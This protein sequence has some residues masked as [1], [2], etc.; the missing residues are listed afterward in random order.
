M[1]NQAEHPSNESGTEENTLFKETL[2]R[3]PEGQLLIAGGLL[4]FGYLVWLG[5][6]LLFSTDQAQVLVGMTATEVIFGRA[7]AMA[8]AYSLGLGHGMVILVCMFL[9]TIQ[10]FLIY[11]LFVFSWRHLLQIRWLKRFFDRLHKAAETHKDKVE[12]YGIIG[13]FAFVWLPFY[14][15]GPVVGSVIGFLLGLRIRWTMAAVLSG[16]FVAI[17]CW[18]LF[19]GKVQKHVASTSSYATFILLI[20]VLIIILVGRVL[21]KTLY[22]NK[23]KK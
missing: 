12:R 22:E 11:P 19:M 15:T 14:M 4:A 13:I 2:L 20:L 8:F 17:F 21:H 3:T 10:V 9:E 6:M 23:N 16:T 5:L 1:E 18:A 7:A